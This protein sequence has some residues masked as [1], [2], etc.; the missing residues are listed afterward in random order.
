MGGGHLG[1]IIRIFLSEGIHFRFVT[2]SGFF[3]NVDLLEEHLTRRE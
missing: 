2:F 3:T 1:V